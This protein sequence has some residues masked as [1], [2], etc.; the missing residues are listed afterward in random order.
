MK[1][2][3]GVFTQVLRISINPII[4]WI[5]RL[6]IFII[7]LMEISSIEIIFITYDVFSPV[8]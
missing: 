8:V 5:V 1:R 4:G 3:F 7:H 2:R 6:T